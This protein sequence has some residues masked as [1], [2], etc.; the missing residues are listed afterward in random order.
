MNHALS[1]RRPPLLETLGWLL[2]LAA[3]LAATAYLYATRP[4]QAISDL[5][6]TRDELR[7]INA[8]LIAP[9]PDNKPM[10]NTEEG[11]AALVADGTLPHLPLDPWG[12]AYQFR[13]PGTIR[14]YELY[15]LGPDGVES[16]DDVVAWNLYGGR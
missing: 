4:T 13:N 6:R 10:P 9:R 1:T 2:P 15:S 11:L 7:A 12:H 5:A 14:A 16:N 3:A 8:A